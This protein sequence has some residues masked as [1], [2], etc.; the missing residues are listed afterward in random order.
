MSCLPAASFSKS[1]STDSAHNYDFLKISRIIWRYVD[2]A[3]GASLAEGVFYRH[4]LAKDY[5]T[6][7]RSHHAHIKTLFFGNVGLRALYAPDGLQGN[8]F[9]EIG[10]PAYGDGIV[11]Y[12]YGVQHYGT[13]AACCPAG[14]IRGWQ[15]NR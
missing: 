1:V 14:C 3:Y 2:R 5:P 6:G 12:E 15:S 13:H 7:V 4:R 10:S 11:I 8:L 9:V